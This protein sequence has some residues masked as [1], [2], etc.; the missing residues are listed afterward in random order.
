MGSVL[1]SIMPDAAVQTAA[2]LDDFRAPV[3]VI[4]AVIL[5]PILFRVIFWAI[6]AMRG[7]A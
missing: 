3:L 2:F 6:A 1:A 4:A 7:E 5:A